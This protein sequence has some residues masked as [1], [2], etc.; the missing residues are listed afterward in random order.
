MLIKPQFEAKSYEVQTGGLVVDP[1]VHQRVCSEIK[2]AIGVL[3]FLDLRIIQSPIKGTK[4]N[5]E[6][7]LIGRWE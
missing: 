7:L 5:Q 3:G 4:G 1:L 6:F 2:T